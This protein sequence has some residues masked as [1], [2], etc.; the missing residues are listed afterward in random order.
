MVNML[1]A[2]GFEEVEALAVVDMLR[3]ADIKINMVS[4]SESSFVTG[5][6]GIKVETDINIKDVKVSDML[7]LPGGVPGVPN[8]KDNKQ[9]LDLIKLYY[10]SDKYI[11]AICAAPSILAELSLIDGK[12]VTSYPSYSDKLG[13]A[14]YTDDSV[15]V[16]GK[17]VTSKACGTV[18]DFAFKII[19]ILKDKDTA[20]KVSKSVYYR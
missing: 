9:V 17:F 3:R 7:V 14:V 10:N 2:D 18:F 20:L 4:V 13:D 5:A 1:F 16:D 12:K 11:A 8:L 19:E 6:H 15:T